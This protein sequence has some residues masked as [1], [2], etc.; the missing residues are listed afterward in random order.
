MIFLGASQARVVLGKGG[1]HFAQGAARKFCGFGEAAFGAQNV[2][3]FAAGHQ[4]LGVVFAE[5]TLQN[6]VGAQVE[7]FGA[8]LTAALVVE[9]CEVH[10]GA[11]GIRMRGTE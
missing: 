5:R 8:G 4:R 1:F 10:H 11:S 6:F 2:G 9:G 3:E 7:L